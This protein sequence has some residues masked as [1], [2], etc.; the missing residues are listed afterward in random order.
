MGALYYKIGDDFP[1]TTN[2]Y[3]QVIVK[4]L[5]EVGAFIFM[6]TFF[7]FGMNLYDTVLSCSLFWI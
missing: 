1:E 5:G 6:F 3:E 2:I 4:Y 7:N